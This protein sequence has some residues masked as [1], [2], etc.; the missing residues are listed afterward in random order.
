MFM[1]LDMKHACGDNSAIFRYK[2]PLSRKSN[3][4]ITARLIS[5]FYVSLVNMLKVCTSKE[6]LNVR[7]CR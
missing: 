5:E 7:K 2:S 6:F 3:I 1:K 4:Q